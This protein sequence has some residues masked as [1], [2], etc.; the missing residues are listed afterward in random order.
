[1]SKLRVSFDEP[2][3]GWIGVTVSDGVETIAI[4]AAA[5]V[6]PFQQLVVALTGLLE[7]RGEFTVTWLE[8]PEETCWR[9]EKRLDDI[10]L[11]VWQSDSPQ[12]ILTAH[13]SY[14]D[15][16]LPF[17]RALQSVKSRSGPQELERKIQSEFPF[18]Q[19][20]R[21]TAK[22]RA[23]KVQPG[24]TTDYPTHERTP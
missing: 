20:E 8:E 6:A 4:D 5:R 13:G 12:P 16:C 19:F 9:F 1:M 7:D 15:I 22:I 18:E 21:L 24:K 23:L 17:W 3:F 11:E 2:E 14:Q 10:L